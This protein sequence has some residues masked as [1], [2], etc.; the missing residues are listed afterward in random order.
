MRAQDSYESMFGAETTKEV[1]YLMPTI[2]PLSLNEKLISYVM[3]KAKKEDKWVLAFVIGTKPCFYKFYGAIEAANKA[4]IPNLVINSNQHYDD[5]LTRGLTEFNIK[6]QV[7]ANLSIRGDLAQKSAEL[8]IKVSWLARYLK[9]KWPN[10]T[11]IPVVLGDTILTP[12][13]PAAWMFSRNEKAIKFLG[14]FGAIHLESGKAQSPTMAVRG[15]GVVVVVLLS[16]F[17]N[18]KNSVVGAENI[19]RVIGKSASAGDYKLADTLYRQ[20]RVSGIEYRVLGAESELEDR[21]YPEKVVE[22]R[23]A[24]LEGKLTEYPD[25]KELYLELS[26]LYGEIENEE[27]AQEYWERARVLDPNGSEFR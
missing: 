13:V 26:R 9:K 14:E 8:M 4:D 24:G 17:L 27:R 21:V 22:R 16:S 3:E 12:I 19:T 10:V 11:V 5:I 7:A 1:D 6:D 23:I 2:L 25:N 15:A 20:Y 18:V